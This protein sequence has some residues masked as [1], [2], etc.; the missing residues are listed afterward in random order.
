[1]N[2]IVIYPG[3]FHPFHRGHLASYEYLTRKYGDNSVYVVT[4]DVTAP[5]TSP[6][7]Y[8]DKVKMITR[9]GIPPGH[10]KRVKNPYQA[11]EIVNALTD[12]EKANTALIFAVSE[13]DMQ[14]KSELNPKGPRFSFGVK[15]NGEPTYLQPLPE[16]LKQI[17]PM[18]QHA[19]VDITPTV[20][21]RVHG[22]DADSAKQIRNLYMRAND[23]DRDKII[24]D[25]YGEAYPDIRDI[26]DSQLGTA[27]R[28]QEFIYGTPIVDAGLKE[29]GIREHKL[30][31]ILKNVQL[32][33]QQVIDSHQALNEA[34]TPPNLD[35]ARAL[36]YDMVDK[37]FDKRIQDPGP[38]LAPMRHEL[39]RLG[40]RL[41]GT[42]REVKLVNDRYN[43]V[44]LVEP[45]NYLE[46][47][48]DY[49]EERWSQK[50]KRSINCSNPRGFSQRAHCA[51]RKK[52]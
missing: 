14:A 49:I 36:A 16:N 51:G 43:Y 25:L 38:L 47:N 48:A 15:K 11:Q 41:R 44:E 31:E 2:F 19:Y 32:L 5:I 24:A 30:Y 4:S 26:F 34:E 45:L 1:M 50:Y 33:E 27:E 17:K 37:M 6:F 10:V 39:Q 7:R 29:P 9:L 18:N 21:F 12:E 46:E 20:P 35:R 3:R 23:Q 28:V 8:E 42:G 22:A 40:F 52:K 13:K